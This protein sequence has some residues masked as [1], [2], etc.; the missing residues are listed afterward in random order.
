MDIIPLS[1]DG[2]GI[3][4]NHKGG[5]TGAFTLGLLFGVGLGPCTFAFLAP[6]L[7]IVFQ[8]SQSDWIKG[9]LMILAFGIGHCAVITFT[10]SLASIAQKYLN[11]TDESMISTYIKRIAGLLVILG[12]VYFI[13]ITF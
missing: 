3:T 1:W 11:W 5:L 7:G 9:F 2:F 8:T 10:G 12:G 4:K 6:I 13:Y